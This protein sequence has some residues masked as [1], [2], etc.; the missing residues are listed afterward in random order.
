MSTLGGPRDTTRPRELVNLSEASRRTG[1]PRKTLSTWATREHLK[2]SGLT[3]DG[4]RV[5]DMA[6]VNRLIA[7]RRAKK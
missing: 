7:T 2:P 5:Y 6:L 3:A 1:V 4:T